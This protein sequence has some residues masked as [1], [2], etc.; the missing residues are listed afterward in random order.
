MRRLLSANG[1]PRYLA[2]TV[3]ADSFLKSPALDI[4][5][6]WTGRVYAEAAIYR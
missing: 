2:H 6:D 3:Q 4:I 1:P 5:V